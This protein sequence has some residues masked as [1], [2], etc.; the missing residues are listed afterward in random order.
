MDGG[1]ATQALR[2]AGPRGPYEGLLPVI[3]DTERVL[4][5]SMAE[6]AY[7]STLN[8]MTRDGRNIP[9]NDHREALQFISQAMVY[10]D[11]ARI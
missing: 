3:A 8:I 5:D 4:A 11:G 9:N 10:R 7:V 1:I 6:A 2:R